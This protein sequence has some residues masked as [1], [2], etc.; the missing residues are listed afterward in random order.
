[1][2]VVAQR[3]LDPN[4]KEIDMLLMD[5]VVA[6][7]YDPV[8]LHRSAAVRSVATLVALV[9]LLRLGLVFCKSDA[10]K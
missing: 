3:L 1:M 10:V 7:A 9:L 5:S 4:A 6:A 2:E 8:S